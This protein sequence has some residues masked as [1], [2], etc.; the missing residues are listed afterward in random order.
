MTHIP[1]FQVG[2][3]AVVDPRIFAVER[4]Q[5]HVASREAGPGNL[6]FIPGGAVP[7]CRWRHHDGAVDGA[8]PF[9]R[10]HDGTGYSAFR[11]CYA[12]ATVHTCSTV[13]QDQSPCVWDIS[14]IGHLLVV[15]VLVADSGH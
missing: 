15:A 1:R 6:P 11:W 10:G 5:G 2:K 7:L 9:C 3:N 12:R 14:A 4:R 8:G 13:S